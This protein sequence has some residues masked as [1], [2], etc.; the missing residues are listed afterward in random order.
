MVD[1]MNSYLYEKE[2]AKELNSTL[3]I[4]KV[5]ITQIV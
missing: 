3:V 1:R 2:K 4:I 5:N